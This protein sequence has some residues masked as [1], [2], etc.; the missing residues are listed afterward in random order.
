MMARLKVALGVYIH[1]FFESNPGNESIA[2]RTNPRTRIIKKHWKAF[3]RHRRFDV[4]D[5]SLTGLYWQVNPQPT[6]NFTACRPG[7]VD[8]PGA[9][10]TGAVRELDGLDFAAILGDTAGFPLYIFNAKLFG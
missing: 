9:R 5:R 6:R 2:F 3:S 4:K 8:A 10:Q 1:R 7:S